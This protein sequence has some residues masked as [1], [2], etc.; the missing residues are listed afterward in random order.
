MYEVRARCALIA[1]TRPPPTRFA[2]LKLFLSF[3]W[4]AVIEN[5]RHFDAEKFSATGELAFISQG[6]C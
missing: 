3:S 4:N 6:I 2:D 1:W 5:R